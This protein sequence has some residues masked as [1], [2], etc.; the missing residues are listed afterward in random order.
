MLSK[1]EFTS[2]LKNISFDKQ[3][4][5]SF[6]RI[7]TLTKKSDEQKLKLFFAALL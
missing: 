5:Y 7:S 6:F 1:Y 3:V 2:T 4:F